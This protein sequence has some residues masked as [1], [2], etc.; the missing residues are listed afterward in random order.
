MVGIALKVLESRPV[1]LFRRLFVAATDAHESDQHRPIILGE[2]IDKAFEGSLLNRVEKGS[3]DGFLVAEIKGSSESF[4][5]RRSGFLGKPDD[6]L[7][8]FE[9]VIIQNWHGRLPVGFAN[10]NPTFYSE[11]DRN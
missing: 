8:D 6:F 1:A 11:P 7:D 9:L 5:P 10:R 3:F 4:R 2:I